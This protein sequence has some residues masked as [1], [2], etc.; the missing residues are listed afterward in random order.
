MMNEFTKEELELI[1]YH[2]ENEPA[3]L[4][5]KIKFMINNYKEENENHL[6]I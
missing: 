4:T 1:Y 2:L 6:I 3:E 5:N